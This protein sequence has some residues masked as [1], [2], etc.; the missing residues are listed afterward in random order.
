MIDLRVIAAQFKRSTSHL[1]LVV[2][3][4]LDATR[5]KGFNEGSVLHFINMTT[6]PGFTTRWNNPESKPKNHYSI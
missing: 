4:C 3:L 2:D 1:A 5:E 6:H